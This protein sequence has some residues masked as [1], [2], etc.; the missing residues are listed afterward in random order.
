MPLG[1]TWYHKGLNGRQTYIETPT[2]KAQKRLKIVITDST[3]CH[4]VL[5]KINYTFKYEIENIRW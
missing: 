1:F 4:F 3:N 5:S 2:K